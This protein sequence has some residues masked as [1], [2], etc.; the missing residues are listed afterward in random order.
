MAGLFNTVTTLQPHT[1][2]YWDV[3]A[4]H[5]AWNASIAALQDRSQQSE[6]LRERASRQ[7]VEL[8]RQILD[9]GIRNNPDKPLLY[10]RLGVLLRD[11]MQD[12]SAA[13]DAF[14]KA[15]TFPDT[16]AYIHRFA[17]YEMAK[18]PGREREAYD[19]LLSLYREGGKGAG[20]RAPDETS[21][22]RDEARHPAG[23]AHPHTPSRI[24]MRC[25]ILGDIH[26]NLQALEAVL[27]DARDYGC[28]EFHCLGDVVGYN[29]NPVE[30]LEIVRELPGTCVMGNHDEAAA[31][32]G[33][34]AGFNTAAALSL[35]WTRTLLGEDHKAWLSS[36]RLQRQIRKS[37][38]VHGSL[39]SPSSWGYIRSAADA[40]MSFVSQ[41]TPFCFDP[42]TPMCRRPRPGHGKIVLVDGVQLRSRRSF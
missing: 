10:E 17:A 24:L 21:R 38:F 18:V 28:G 39:D 41:R 25:A 20:S 33:S 4:W 31:G 29:A 16:R 13:A 27:A 7:Y 40:A 23:P 9:N 26:G 12:H 22:T 1:L 19:R 11:K 3:A 32:N 34:L 42:A 37:T 15:A 2:L 8:G 36:L 35:E 30:C 5:M 14:A 6:A